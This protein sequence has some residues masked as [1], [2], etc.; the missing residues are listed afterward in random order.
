MLPNDD[1]DP[2]MK[3]LRKFF[4]PEGFQMRTVHGGQIKTLLPTM[5]TIEYDD[6]IVM[7]QNLSS[8]GSFELKHELVKDKDVKKNKCIY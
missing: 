2:F 3:F 1:D 5:E 6:R 7:V 4:N 8:L